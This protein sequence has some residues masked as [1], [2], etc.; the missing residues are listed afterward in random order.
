MLRSGATNTTGIFL[1]HGI[2]LAVL[3]IILFGVPANAQ[4]TK[5]DSRKLE[6]FE[7]RIRPVLI[8]HCFPCHSGESDEIKGGL[9][10]DSR[11]A[12]I[13]GGDSGTAI[14]PFQPDKS[15]LLSA[16][17][18][19][20][21]EMP[22]DGKLPDAILRD[23]EKWIADGAHDPRK[24]EPAI[25]QKSQPARKKID[26]ERGRRFWAFRPVEQPA[27]P[28]SPG[29]RAANPI[30]SFLLARLQ[31]ANLAASGPADRQTLIRRLTYDLTGLPPTL[32]DVEEFVRDD[33]PDAW[34]RRIDR[35]LGSEQFGVHWGRHWLDVARYADSNGGDFN[36]TFHNAWRYRN[37]VI[38]SW[39]LDKPF[40]QFVR[41]QIAGD[42][43]PAKDLEDQRQKIIATGFL[44]L[45]TKMLSERDKEKLTMD[46][47]DEQINAVGQ[48][49]LGL[50]LGC[51]RCHDHKFDPIPTQDYYALAGIFKSTRTLE[52]ESQ[53]YVSTWP[54]RNL[55]IPPEQQQAIQKYQAAKKPLS[56]RIKKLNSRIASLKK[57]LEK[58]ESGVQALVVDDID[59]RK[60]GFWK[61]STVSPTYFGKGYIHD[62]KSEKGEKWVE[63]SLDLPRS[64]SYEVQVSYNANSGRD[65]AVPVGIRHADGEQETLLNQQKKPTV[66]NLFQPVGRFRFEKGQT[67]RVTIST[68]GT[69]LYVIVDA[70]RW[71]ELDASGKPV[72][73]SDPVTAKKIE[74][75]RNELKTLTEQLNTAQDR[76]RQLE[77]RKPPSVPQAFAVSEARKIGDC[78]LRIR[79]E[80]GNPGA[81]VPRGFVQ[82]VSAGASPKIDH[83]AS[84]RKEL[85]DWIAAP[86]NPLTARVL[87]NRIWYHLMGEGIVRSLDNFGELGQRP[88]HPELLDFLASYLV[89]H[90]WS[91]KD[92]IRLIV[93]SD[94]Y[95]MRSTYREDG[96]RVDPEN[97]LLWRMH[98]KRLTAESIRD[99]LLFI[100]G[101]LDLA[102]GRSPVEGL[103]VLVTQNTAN[104]KKYQRN[105]LPVRS[106]FLPIIRSELPDFLQLFDF[107]DPDLVTGKRPK[108]S[109]PAQALFLLN[110]PQV[111]GQSKKI[112]AR[113]LRDIPRDQNGQPDPRMLIQRAY[114]S[115]LLRQPTS[116]ELVS[117]T[118][119]LRNMAARGKPESAPAQ[120]IHALIISTEF[121]MLD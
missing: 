119:F 72:K 27:V 9:R 62:D 35:L 90:D 50:T 59:A 46:V 104:E 2:L 113:I 81:L 67:A 92:L 43:L 100:S 114:R 98:R 89:E 118:T 17:R 97:R 37:Y 75:A 77:S 10:V 121:R 45:G 22:P 30:D 65:K 32:Q 110:S 51:A 73:R 47:V 23:F 108:T 31:R 112:A 83:R 15:L 102:L 85:A 48:A 71:I 28:S 107:A 94:A 69:S 87:A 18:Y 44:M 49:F 80:S 53:Q 115:V 55:P 116:T 5:D 111:I 38:D 86:G 109:V 16:M 1:K 70:V 60:I 29:A 7:N 42:L 66:D 58:L 12:L 21:A 79:G 39:N 93:T 64:G 33:R 120:L 36:A 68:R 11:P 25:K 41:E 78:R 56:A 8:K 63:F 19:D 74:Q 24:T 88:T 101:D 52:G 105:E 99:S 14:V 95:R 57:N 26:L 3:M 76:L 20:E 103:G 82:V 84:G 106:A 40:D 54:K 117:G 96:Q 61:P 13:R 6:F 91:C 34:Q 4:V